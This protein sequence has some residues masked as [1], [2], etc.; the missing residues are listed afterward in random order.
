MPSI[1]LIGV[2]NSHA[3][4][5]IRFLNQEGRYAGFRATA[6][7]GGMD[8]RSEALAEAGGIETIVDDASDLVGRVDAAIISTRDGALHRSQAEPLLAAGIPVLVD[9]PLATSV[10]DADAIL[11]AAR[12]SGA[13]VYSASALRF[14]RQVGQLKQWVRSSTGLRHLHVTGAGDA[15][16]PYSGL[17]F[18][19][20]HHVEAALEVLGD[21]PLPDGIRVAA[22]QS[23]GTTVAT[24]QLDEVVIT[25]T[26]VPPH[27]GG[28]VGFHAGAVSADDLCNAEIELGRDYNAPVLNRFISSLRS[29]RA[30]V[31]PVV[32]RTP[33]VLMEKICAAL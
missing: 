12:A 4:H 21:S 3:E 25:L 28:Q 32:M 23:A 10:D 9:K 18:Y 13:M 16:G 26:F 11:S 5:F 22:F 33:I 14:A 31:E 30:P 29:G 1:G 19:G 7:A 24:V 15:A 27:D 6:L 8:A 2:E 20:I 17:Y